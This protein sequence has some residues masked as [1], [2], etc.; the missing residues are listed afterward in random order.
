MKAII[1]TDIR[2][3]RLDSASS[4]SLSPLVITTNSYNYIMFCVIRVDEKKLTT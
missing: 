3:K 2:A 4:I 1:P